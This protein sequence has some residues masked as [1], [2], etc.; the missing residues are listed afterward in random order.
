MSR[1]PLTTTVEQLAAL[2]NAQLGEFMEK[3]RQP[4]GAIELPVDGWEKLS[5]IERDRLAER[6]QYVCI[7]AR[8]SNQ[9]FCS[10]LLPTQVNTASSGG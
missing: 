9:F 1:S 10:H 6:L 7:P 2:S 3:N 8:L 5:K 4:N